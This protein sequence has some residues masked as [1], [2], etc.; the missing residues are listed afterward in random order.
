MQIIFFLGA[1]IPAD[2]LIEAAA[3]ALVDGR[4]IIM[5]DNGKFSIGSLIGY[6]CAFKAPLTE[7]K[8]RVWV[9]ANLRVKLNFDP[10]AVLLGFDD[11][12]QKCE[13][14]GGSLPMIRNQTEMDDATGLY[15]FL[16]FV[17]RKFI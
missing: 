12:K 1:Q 16:A 14:A 8:R 7:E 5:E 17:N 11:A 3:A 13:D 6:P 15:A 10:V 9:D 4:N 2:S